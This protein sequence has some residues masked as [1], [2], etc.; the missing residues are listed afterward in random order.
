M[1][2]F[3]YRAK[4][5]RNQTVTGVLDVSDEKTVS[6]MLRGQGLFVIDIK[7]NISVS[8]FKAFSAHFSKGVGSSDIVNFTRQLSVMISAGLTITEALTAIR[9]QATNRSLE[10]LVTDLSVSVEGGMSFSDGLARH[11]NVFPEIYVAVVQSGET[12]GILDTMLNRLADNLEKERELRGKV[13]GALLYPAI[14]LVGVIGVIAAMMIFVVPQMSNL[15]S[16]LNIELPFTTKIVIAV[17]NFFTALWYIAF[18]LMAGIYI[19]FSSWRKT[20]S[21]KKTFDDFVLKTPA[22]GK[23]ETATNVVEISRTLALLVGAGTPIIEALNSVGRGARNTLF[24]EAV[25][26]VAKKVEKGLSLTVAFSH[27]PIFPAL[28][29]QMARVGE[30][31]GKLDE[32]MLKMSTYFE[33][34]VER[35]VKTFTTLLEPII[36][37]MLA[38]VVGF[39]MISVIMPI[40]S[41]TQ[42]L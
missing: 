6:S 23:L 27:E 1:T 30:E 35:S 29:V 8:F 19:G 2:K 20:A 18:L 38:L 26:R 33:S 40:Y 21:G 11:K 42:A 10:K 28:I 7:P 13:K 24:Q 15:Y 32:V 3:S 12:S 14:I 36:L 16:Q 22:W 39:I 17:S 25:F 4:D 41:I 37:I 34:E 9:N 31:A 5:N